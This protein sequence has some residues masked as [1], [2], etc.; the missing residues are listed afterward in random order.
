[1]T[2][3]SSGPQGRTSSTASP[4][5]T[6][7]AA[8]TA[9]TPSTAGPA[10]TGSS[11]SRVGRPGRAAPTTTASWAAGNDTCRGSRGHR[12]APD[13]GD[14]HR[15]PLEPHPPLPR[16]PPAPRRAFALVGALAP[17][18]VRR[19]ARQRRRRRRESRHRQR[20]PRRPPRPPQ[21]RHDHHGRPVRPPAWLGTRVLPLRPDGF[22]R[23]PAHADRARPRRIQQPDVL[24]A[25]PPAT[26]SS[27]RSSW[28]PPDVVARSTWSDALPVTLDELRYVTVTFWGSAST[29]GASCSSRPAADDP[30]EVFRASTR[31]LPDRGD[32]GRAGRR[33]RPPADRR[34]QQ[35][36]RLRLPA[37]PGC[38]L[39]VAARLRARRRREPVPQPV[40]EGRPRPAPEL[41]SA[42]TDRAAPTR[43]CST[44]GTRWSAPSPRSAGA[45]AAT[46][47]A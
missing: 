24:P 23:D 3:S 41:A 10:T 26:P 16:A 31:P 28:S 14:P 43:A 34:Q 46:G 29:T 13:P 15:L 18:G 8:A 6:A 22:W 7:S 35:H 44:T 1:M 20:R 2:T 37:H 4:A 47:P 5:T 33:A 19:R 11:G 40:R 36:Q 39:L 9:A 30:V 32:A 12:H 27:R 21:R 17:G 38:H 25:P 45:G 42:Y